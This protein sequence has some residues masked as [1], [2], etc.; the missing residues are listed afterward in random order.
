[1][2]FAGLAF[3]DCLTTR[4]KFIS[5]AANRHCSSSSAVQFPDHRRPTCISREAEL[6]SDC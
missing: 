3:Y 2:N 6:A 4:I 1:M 5:L